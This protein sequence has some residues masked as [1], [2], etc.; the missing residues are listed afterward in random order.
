MVCSMFQ[1]TSA[2]LFVQ[3]ARPCNVKLCQGFRKYIYIYIY[4][5][6]YTYDEGINGLANVLSVEC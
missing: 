6:I 2:I 3:F 5:Y 1:V 4:I